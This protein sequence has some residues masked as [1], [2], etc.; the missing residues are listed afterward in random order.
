[1]KEGDKATRGQILVEFDS[2]RCPE[3]RIFPGLLLSSSPTP[4]SLRITV[5]SA[6]GTVDV[7]D[8]LLVVM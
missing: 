1:M 7:A 5:T 4:I 8:E 6:S 3:S 2:G